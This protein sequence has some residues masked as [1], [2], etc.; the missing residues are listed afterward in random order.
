[1]DEEVVHFLQLVDTLVELDIR[2][3]T[4]RDSDRADT[5]LPQPVLDKLDTDLFEQQLDTGGQVGFIEILRQATGDLLQGRAVIH[6]HGVLDLPGFFIT[7]ELAQ[8]V[9]IGRLP[10][11]GQA[12]D[13]AFVAFSLEA[14]Q[15]RDVGIEI[16]KRIEAIDRRKTRQPS[17]LPM[18]DT[19]GEPIPPSIEGDDQGNVIVAR[20]V[21]A[22]RVTEMMVI[23][24]DRCGDPILPFQKLRDLVQPLSGEDTLQLVMSLLGEGDIPGNRRQSPTDP[25]ERARLAGVFGIEPAVPGNGLGLEDAYFL[26]NRHNIDVFCSNACIQ[27]HLFDGLAGHAARHFHPAQPLLGNGGEDLSILEDGSGRRFTV[28]DAQNDHL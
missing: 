21:G 22:G 19:A 8:N 20:V 5:R 7:Y 9:D 6:R 24:L 10:K 18:I 3:H 25:F 12:G 27:H 17:I 26:G 15:M 14:A 28:Y 11:R 16:S 4:T 23:I 13:L 2:K 1:M